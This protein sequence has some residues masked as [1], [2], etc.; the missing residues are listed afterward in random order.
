MTHEVIYNSFSTFTLSTFCFTLSCGF[1]GKVLT[2]IMKVDFSAK[3]VK[4]VL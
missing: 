2:D 1:R 4:T 3:N